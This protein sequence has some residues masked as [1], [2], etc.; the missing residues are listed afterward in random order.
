MSYYFTLSYNVASIVFMFVYYIKFMDDIMLMPYDVFMPYY[1][2]RARAVK[3]FS[4]D[5]LAA[6]VAAI[7]AIATHVGISFALKLCS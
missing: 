4:Y 3:H 2:L 1:T 7:C 6:P 5:L